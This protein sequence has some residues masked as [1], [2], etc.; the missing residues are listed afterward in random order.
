MQVRELRPELNSTTGLEKERETGHD[1][2]TREANT[3]DLCG[4]ERPNGAN[5][6]S[7]TEPHRV[8][9]IERRNGANSKVQAR[10][11]ETGRWKV[12]RA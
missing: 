8:Q 6:G 12:L 9:R 7:E 10:R 2:S 11:C 3:E 1:E 5:R 4:N